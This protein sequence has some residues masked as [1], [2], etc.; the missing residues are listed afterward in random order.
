MISTVTTTT[1]TTISTIAL[2]TSIEIVAILALI[3]FL[4]QKEVFSFTSTPK[5]KAIGNVL[6]RILTFAIVPL[7]V[8]FAFI[9]I[10]KIGEVLQ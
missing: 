9:V 2:A 4:I 1:I 6:S 10:V 5:A 7:I 3:L 8:S